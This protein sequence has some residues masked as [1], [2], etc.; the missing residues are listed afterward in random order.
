MTEYQAQ[1]QEGILAVARAMCP[2]L[3]DLGI[4]LLDGDDEKLRLNLL[5][6]GLAQLKL[7]KAGIIRAT[8]V[9]P[10]EPA[11]AVDLRR[12]RLDG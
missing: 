3:G 12:G 6:M 4:F 11:M 9:R 10:A 5:E 1:R 2:E 8:I 7:I